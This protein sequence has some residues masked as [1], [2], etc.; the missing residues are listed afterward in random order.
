MGIGFQ[1]NGHWIPIQWALDLRVKP[2]GFP[3][4]AHWI[5]TP[6]LRG[7]AGALGEALRLTTVPAPPDLRNPIPAARKICYNMRM[8]K[9]FTCPGSKMPRLDISIWSAKYSGYLTVAE[10]CAKAG[11]GG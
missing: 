6:L 8:V 11:R 10:R 3:A 9:I 7:G 1:F 2:I 5:P 4:N